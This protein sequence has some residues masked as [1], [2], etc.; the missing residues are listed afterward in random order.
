MYALTFSSE[1]VCTFDS[2]P[3]LNDEASE[4]YTGYVFAHSPQ[5]TSGKL[6]FTPRWTLTL[7]PELLPAPAPMREQSTVMLVW[8][9]SVNVADFNPFCP[10][11]LSPR[12]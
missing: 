6:D 5:L 10:E 12:M 8:L 9:C 7:K 1:Q 11:S 4:A 3:G 2:Y